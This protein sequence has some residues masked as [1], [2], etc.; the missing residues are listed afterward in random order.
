M[1]YHYIRPDLQNNP[2]DYY[3]SGYSGA[4]F[5]EAWYEVRLPFL[6]L[7][8]VNF[9]KWINVKSYL[10]SLNLEDETS[11][12]LATELKLMF[13][14]NPENSEYQQILNSWVRMFEVK[15]KLP[16]TAAELQLRRRDIEIG[17]HHAYLIL[18]LLMY[19][20]YLDTGDYAALNCFIKLI[21]ILISISQEILPDKLFNFL[22]A[23]EVNELRDIIKDQ[24]I[25]WNV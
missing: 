23:Q 25:L 7:E 18:A 1:K 5:F 24:D 17:K 9:K 3:Y 13:H 8:V 11:V 12:K 14:R 20:G 22:V 2:E 10:V 21:D 19:K 4:E 16:L 6:N 15:K